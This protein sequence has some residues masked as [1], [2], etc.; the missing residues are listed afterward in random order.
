MVTDFNNK[1]LQYLLA[2][3]K[4]FKKLTRLDFLQPDNSVAFS[5]GNSF[6]KRGYMT[7]YDSKAFIQSG[8]LDVSLN[9]GQRRKA[10]VTLSNL[11]S[12]FDYAVNKIWFG[13]R[14]RLEMGIVLPDG[15]DF[16]LPQGVFYIQNPQNVFKP[17][18]KTIT[19]PLVDKWT[20]LD[21]TLAGRL[22]EAYT[23]KN[24]LNADGTSQY[25]VNIFNAMRD[26]LQLSKYTQLSTT[27]PLK[28]YDNVQPIFTT[29]YNSPD[30]VYNVNDSDGTITRTIQMTQ[31]PYDIIEEG[32]ST[33]A[34]V[35]LALNET[36]A[37]MIG[38]DQ[39]GALRVEPSQED[40]TDA[41]KPILW[42]F[43]PQNSLLLGLNE[44]IKNSEVFNDV[45]VIGEGSTGAEVWGRATNYD[46][47]SDTNVNLIG[48]KTLRESKATFW[49][50]KQCVDWAQWLLKRKT[51]LQ[52]SVSIQS[53]QLFH[54]IENRLITVKRTDKDGSPVERHLINSFSLPLGETGEMTINATS[55]SDF[56]IATTK[57]YSSKIGEITTNKDIRAKY[58]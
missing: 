56:P 30:K 48:L 54:L 1:Y 27:D 35:M 31:L 45:F 5:L 39:T 8:T 16:Y 42:N 53:S 17:N 26:L 15:S 41:T 13:Q 51:I 52:K 36:I 33:I 28:M 49:N 23:I 7:H 11:D 9:N 19:F 58:E 10:S 37:G 50:S 46:P 34:N 21:G 4:P 40:I 20:Y 47:S 55:I 6:V 12:A 44:T 3:G 14:L 25:N 57:Q 38:Y 29:Y 2:V 22:Y 32:G 18:E 43:T 24:T